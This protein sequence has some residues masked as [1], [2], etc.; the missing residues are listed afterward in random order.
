MTLKIAV[1]YGICCNFDGEL[2]ILE[3]QESFPVL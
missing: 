2:K 1:V 3:E